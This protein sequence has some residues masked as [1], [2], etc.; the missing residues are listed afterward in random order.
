MN[1]KAFWE[2]I[3]ALFNFEFNFY[4]TEIND[5]LEKYNDS[6][7]LLGLIVMIIVIWVLFKL[8]WKLIRRIY[9]H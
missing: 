2:R 6:F 3:K 4:F 8:L 1:L 7:R 5:V 9:R